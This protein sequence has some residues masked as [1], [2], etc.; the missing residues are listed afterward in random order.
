MNLIKNTLRDNII[1]IDS[2]IKTILLNTLNL[3]FKYSKDKKSISILLKYI[4]NKYF[5]TSK[6][7]INA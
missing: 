3:R 4:K 1:N 2:I 6:T 5:D 7:L